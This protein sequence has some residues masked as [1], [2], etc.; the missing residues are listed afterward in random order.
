ML[1]PCYQNA[2]PT[3]TKSR[4]KELENIHSCPAGARGR[5]LKMS[6]CRS[7]DLQEVGTERGR[8]QCLWN[9]W[10]LSSIVQCYPCNSLQGWICGLSAG[11][12][13]WRCL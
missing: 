13:G 9:A 2:A 12:G 11:D 7:V 1:A 8:D 3:P 4:E 5:Q 6:D 10:Y